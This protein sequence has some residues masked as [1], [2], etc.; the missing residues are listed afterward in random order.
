MAQSRWR[1]E[2]RGKSQGPEEDAGIFSKAIEQGSVPKRAYLR[3][4][5]PAEV[6]QGKQGKR[7]EAGKPVRETRFDFFH[8]VNKKGP[9]PG[10]GK[11]SRNEG[12]NVKSIVS[13]SYSPI[14]VSLQHY[15]L[16]I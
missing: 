5:N 16:Q 7:L 13:N 2:G 4:I 3:H 10:G 8:R 1:W 14:C 15:Y 12:K 6:M 9:G 11:G